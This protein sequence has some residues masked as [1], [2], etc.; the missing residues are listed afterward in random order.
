MITSQIDTAPKRM[1]AHAMWEGRHRGSNR[2]VPAPRGR[3]LITSRIGTAFQNTALPKMSAARWTP[4]RGQF[5][6]AKSLLLEALLISGYSLCP[7]SPPSLPSI[8][9]AILRR[10]P[11]KVV[12][13]ET[14]SRP[15]VTKSV[16]H[17]H[18]ECV[19]TCAGHR[20]VHECVTRAPVTRHPGDA[21]PR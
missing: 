5:D 14:V 17:S 9:Q 6:F 11:G 7:R 2:D 19:T 3:R 12:L 21:A 8:P 20:I 1:R 13:E 18:A 4:R 16:T 15:L 10:T